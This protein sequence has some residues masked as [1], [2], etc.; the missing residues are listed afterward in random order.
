MEIGGAIQ[1]IRAGV[2]IAKGM[3]AASKAV[4]DLGRQG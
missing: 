3:V 4:N 2:E 1:A